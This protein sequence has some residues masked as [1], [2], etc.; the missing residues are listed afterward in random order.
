MTNMTTQNPSAILD[1]LRQDAP[2][3][4]TPRQYTPIGLDVGNGAVKLFSAMGEIL[5]ESYIVYQAERATY[6]NHGYAEYVSGDRSDLTGKIWIGGVNAYL[7]APTTINRTVDTKDGKVAQCLQ[8]L[9]SS[10]SHYPH[11]PEWDLMIA[12][13][14]HDGKVF[15]KQVR[16][17]LQ[18]THRVRLRGKESTVNIVV[19]HVVEEGTGA[20]VAIHQ[21]HD[22]SSALVIDLGHG[23]GIASSFNGLHLS[24]REYSLES[25]AESLIH[26]IANSEFVRKALLKPG[27]KHLIR[28]GIEKGNFSYGTQ[29]PDWQFKE[30]YIA[31]FPTWFSQGLA[32]FVK[33]LESRVPAASS[34]IAIGGGACL[35]G[36]TSALAKKGFV[37]P[38]QPRWVNAQGL[39]QL[40]L[41]AAHQSEADLCA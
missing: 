2:E 29:R 4:A 21:R 19:S 27:D 23:T 17:A 24:Y 41:R 6:A 25:G 14:I 1:P 35:P 7:S 38:D 5:L 8:L 36:M 28:A 33:L 18:G 15:G 16:Q 22:F 11:R 31:E 32:Q 3:R 26:A 39:Y 40:A 20:A 9:I 12:C 37:I 13:S 34:L 10:L 30:A